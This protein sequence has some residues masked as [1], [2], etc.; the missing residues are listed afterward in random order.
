MKKRPNLKAKST[1]LIEENRK[2][3]AILHAL[4]FS[5]TFLNIIK[6]NNT[7]EIKNWDSNL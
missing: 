2:T 1:Q 3:Q 6:A 5:T 4:K 7:T